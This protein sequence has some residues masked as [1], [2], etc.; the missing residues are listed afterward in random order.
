MSHAKPP[1]PLLVFL[2]LLPLMS[3]LGQPLAPL[4][5]IQSIGALGTDL[6]LQSGSTGMVLVVVREDQVFFRGY[7]QTAPNSHPFPTQDSLLRLCS[8]TK[9]FTTD[10]LTKLVADKTV[11]LDDPLQRYAP[12]AL[13]C[14]NAFVASRSPIWR[15]THPVSR[16]N[17]ETLLSI[18]RTSPSPTTAPAGAGWKANV[19]AALPVPPRSTRIWRS[20]SSAMPPVRCTQAIRRTSRGAHSQP[21]PNAAHDVLFQ[22]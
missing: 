3:A 11:R 13:L 17:W 7:G 20:I 15:H 8:L 5:D 12:A 2:F 6:F 14:P 21:A 4:P 1:L 22:C 19:S 16:E 10:V 18:L 9:I